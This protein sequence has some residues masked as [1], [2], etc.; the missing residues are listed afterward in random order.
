MKNINIL[1]VF[2]AVSMLFIL[3]GPA[4]ATII[5][6]NTPGTTAPPATLGPYTMT[7]FGD[8][9]RT[10]GN[11]VSSVPSPVGGNV[12]FI[13]DLTHAKVGSGWSTWSHGYTGDVYI[14]WGTSAQ[15]TMPANTKAF[16]LYAEP[17]NFGQYYIN[18]TSQSGTTSTFGP[19]LVEGSAGAQYFGFYGDAGETI[20]EID[21]EIDS[22]A[23][24]MAVGEFGIN[25]GTGTSIPEFPTLA[26]PV[27]SVVG[28][29]FLFQRKKAN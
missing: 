10:L 23:A 26:I 19:F 27:L 22:Q 12:G 5:F 4:S 7:P 9:A 21:M 15:M 1:S 28:L 24:G 16:Y 6:Y 2:I 14:T 29:M 18:A 8:D 13:A 3:A 17:D 25:V 20:N 11:L